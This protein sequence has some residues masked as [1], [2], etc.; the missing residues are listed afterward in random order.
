MITRPDDHTGNH[1][2]EVC[3]F[4]YSL[5]PKIWLLINSTLSSCCTSAYSSVMKT[6]VLDQENILYLII[7]SIL[8]T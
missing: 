8:I 4:F 1:F 7:L 6:F 5:T 2:V 3:E